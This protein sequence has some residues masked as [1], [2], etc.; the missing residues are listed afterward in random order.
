MEPRIQYAQSADGVSIALC[1][2][3]RLAEK[4]KLAGSTAEGPDCQ[5]VI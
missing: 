1:W 3:E 5:S 2:Y 4:R